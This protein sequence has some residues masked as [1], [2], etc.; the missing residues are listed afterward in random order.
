MVDDS[1][2]RVMALLREAQ[3]LIGEGEVRLEVVSA[4]VIEWVYVGLEND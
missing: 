2:Q 1:E 4:P 3:V